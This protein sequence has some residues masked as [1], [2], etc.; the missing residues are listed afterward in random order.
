ML[1]A[2]TSFAPLAGRA[3]V[4][5]DFA[6]AG[7]ATLFGLGL[8]YLAN[9]MLSHNRPPDRAEELAMNE[10]LIISNML[11]WVAVLALLVVVIALSRQVGILYERMAPMGALMMDSGPKVGDAAPVFDA[12]HAGR[13]RTRASARASA[14]HAAVLPVAD[15]PGVQEAAADPEV[16]RRRPK[17]SGSTSCSPATATPSE[18]QD[19]RR[20]AELGCLPLRAV[21]RTRHEVPCRQAALCGADRRG[22]TG[23]C[24]GAGQFARTARQPVRG[25]GTRRRLGAG[26]SRIRAGLAKEQA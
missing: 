7:F 15:L 18:H 11:L 8:Y 16:G 14:Q 25:E 21:D 9:A 1:L 23:A 20:R 3:V 10:A 5:L 17:A 6:A 19:F 2:L 12:A 13:Q 26:L 4:W 24:Q 22:R